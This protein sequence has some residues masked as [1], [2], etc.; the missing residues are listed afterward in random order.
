[1]L[2]QGAIFSFPW[3]WGWLSRCHREQT[4]AADS[5][6]LTAFSSSLCCF[7]SP[8]TLA[9]ASAGDRPAGEEPADGAD[10]GRIIGEMV[11]FGPVASLSGIALMITGGKL[12]KEGGC[13]NGSGSLAAGFSP[14]GEGKAASEASREA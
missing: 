3:L 1:M 6:A 12:A 5:A 7:S 2:S 9:P 10:G 14:S 13:W 4:S 11:G 8:G